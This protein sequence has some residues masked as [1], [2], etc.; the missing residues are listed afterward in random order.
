MTDRAIIVDRGYRTYDGERRGTGAAVGAIIRDGFRRVLGLRRKARSKLF[1][2]ALIGLMVMLA[3]LFVLIQWIAGELTDDL[4][5][6]GEYFDTISA[7]PILFMALAAPQLLVPDR[8]QGVLAV[9]LSRPLRM[10]DYLL[11]KGIALF[12]LMMA[13]YLTPQLILHL[14]LAGLAPEGFFTYLGDN[15]DVLWKVPVVAFVYFCLHGSL[16][17][18]VASYVPRIGFAAGTYLGIV[19]IANRLAEFLSEAAFSGARWFAFLAFEQH[20]RYVRD[21]VFDLPG[22]TIMGAAGFEPWAAL[23]AV[24]AIVAA[25]AVAVWAQYRRLP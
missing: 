13:L 14:G 21:W 19:I 11:A 4:P 3:A 12:T 20:P 16:A 2:W 1:P 6:Y 25:S 17:V 5:R 7:L 15:A 18:A 24:G 23:A 8:T 22:Q 9:Y 10:G